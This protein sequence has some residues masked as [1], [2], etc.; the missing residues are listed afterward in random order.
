[1]SKIYNIV[2]EKLAN[3][4]N[5]TYTLII[6]QDIINLGTEGTPRLVRV[7]LK[8]ESYGDVIK[9]GIYKKEGKNMIMVTSDEITAKVDAMLSNKVFDGIDLSPYVEGQNL[10]ITVY[11]DFRLI[12]IVTPAYDIVRKVATIEN[13]GQSL[14]INR[15][16][17]EVGLQY[18]I[19]DAFEPY[20]LK[21]YTN[22]VNLVL[23][24]KL[25]SLQAAKFYLALDAFLPVNIYGPPNSFIFNPFV[26]L[27]RIRDEFKKTYIFQESEKT[28]IGFY[29][30]SITFL[31]SKEI[32]K[33][34]G[35][36]KFVK[37]RIPFYLAILSGCYSSYFPNN[38]VRLYVYVG[39]DEDA[40]KYPKAMTA[41][42]YRANISWTE[43]RYVAM[44]TL[45]NLCRAS[46][47]SLG[48]G[49]NQRDTLISMMRNKSL[50]YV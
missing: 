32:C 23:M 19:A 35:L 21:A 38:D 13:R 10:K 47:K 41:E 22:I 14:I 50:L 12:H 43:G 40:D 7:M 18:R 42:N 31:T 28:K 33:G 8:Q 4:K 6:N 29:E 9:V 5:K 17:M 37:F 44:T 11:H 15:M 48:L 1:M 25:K 16:P 36:D 2:G 20:A 27:P 49:E 45:E 26:Y 30:L 39:D 3:S 24:K 46:Y 34:F